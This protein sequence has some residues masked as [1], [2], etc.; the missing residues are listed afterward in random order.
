M[1]RVVW[2]QDESTGAFTFQRNGETV[3]KFSDP[4]KMADHF[5][6]MLDER[7]RLDEPCECGF[8]DV[9][10]AECHEPRNWQMIF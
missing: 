3:A 9:C 6:L 4:R 5:A 10:C 7:H 1:N 8:R 2:T